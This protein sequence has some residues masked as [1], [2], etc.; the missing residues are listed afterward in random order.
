MPLETLLVLKDFVPDLT[1]AEHSQD[2]P[3]IL[4]KFSS[5]SVI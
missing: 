4:L 2:R 3:L 1:L 5:A